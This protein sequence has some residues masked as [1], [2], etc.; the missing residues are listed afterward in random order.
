[1]LA[2][3]VKVGQGHF[4]RAS[5]AQTEGI[6]GTG[7]GLYLCRELV[8]LHGGRIWCESVEGQGSTFLWHSPNIRLPPT[9]RLSSPVWEPD[10]REKSA[11]DP[12]A[13]V[14]TLAV[15]FVRER[16]SINVQKN[17]VFVAS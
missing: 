11:R 4:A 7:L 5:N 13:E 3:S 6:G 1:M 12:H 14:L 8:E 17:P 10:L 2:G 16:V 15:T 9:V